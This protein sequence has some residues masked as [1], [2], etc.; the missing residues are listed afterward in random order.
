MRLF[1]TLAGCALVM[2]TAAHVQ[3]DIVTPSSVTA[4]TEF[5]AAV[6]L[7]NGSG[8]QDVN[9]TPGDETDDLHDNNE[10]NMWQT[11]AATSIGETAEFNLG[12]TY[13]LSSAIVWQYNGLNGF[14]LPEIDREVDEIDIAISPN[15]IDPF[16]SIGSINL[17]GAADQTVAPPGGEAAQ[18]FA[19][20]LNPG[21]LARR[22]QFTILSILNPD[23]VGNPDDPNGTDG[24][25][26]LSE[27]RFEGVIAPEPTSLAIASM[28]A[29]AI[30]WLM[31]RRRRS[32]H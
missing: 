26:G 18:V 8:L 29:V 19:L 5:A 16:V 17:A 15:L 27:V 20:N 6:N 12:H 13:Q 31:R 30:P 21:D 11:F 23:F 9:V 1:Q 2:L 7:I 32:R 4:S 28:G 3:A 25:A 10:N 24:A 22:V 14:G